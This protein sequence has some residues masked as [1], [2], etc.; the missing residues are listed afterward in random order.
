MMQQTELGGEIEDSKVSLVQPC[1]DT[2]MVNLEKNDNDLD[3]RF[4]SIVAMGF[5]L[6]SCHSKLTQPQINK[7][8]D[9]YQKRAN[10][11]G[12]R[13]AALRAYAE[14]GN[15]NSEINLQGIDKLVPVLI[16]QLHQN[17]RSVQILGLK[18]IN[19]LLKRYP[20]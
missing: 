8:M 15:N 6:S 18:A 5:L 10:V 7:V 9:I 14:L 3:V 17:N 11:E 16:D 2:L 1:Y 13:E 4:N 20:D 19:A 12:T